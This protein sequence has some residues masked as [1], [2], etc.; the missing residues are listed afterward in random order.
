MT[1]TMTMT[2]SS[3]IRFLCEDEEAY[4]G[5]YP[6]GDDGEDDGVWFGAGIDW[7]G[8]AFKEVICE[9]GFEVADEKSDTVDTANLEK[10]YMISRRKAILS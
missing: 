5:A 7:W 10:L 4:D 9:D 1:I 8:D 6:F 2:S 3:K